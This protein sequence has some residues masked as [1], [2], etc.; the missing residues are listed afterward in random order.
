M[1]GFGF[2]AHRFR[3]QSVSKGGVRRGG[4]DFEAT[5]N[6]SGEEAWNMSSGH[7]TLMVIS[8][9]TIRGTEL[10]KITKAESSKNTWLNVLHLLSD[11]YNNSTEYE[12]YLIISS[13]NMYPFHS[14]MPNLESILLR[15]CIAWD[16]PIALVVCFLV[17][18]PDPHIGIQIILPRRM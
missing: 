6:S 4:C 9:K 3:T 18:I 10:W 17:S 8:C 5:K 2:S 11:I 12:S 13:F 7:V 16:S 14:S 1:P 15:G